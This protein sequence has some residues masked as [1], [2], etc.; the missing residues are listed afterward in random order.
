MLNGDAGKLTLRPND[1]VAS[2]PIFRLLGAAV[3][4]KMFVR[5]FRMR[6]VVIF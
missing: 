1:R 3:E 6:V 4:L 2:E 5:W